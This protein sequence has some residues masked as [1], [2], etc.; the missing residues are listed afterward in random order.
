[1][2]EAPLA[3]AGGIEFSGMAVVAGLLYGGSPIGGA[4]GLAELAKQFSGMLGPNNQL[5]RGLDLSQLG[6]IGARPQA[7]RPRRRDGAIASG[8]KRSSVDDPLN[9]MREFVTAHE[10]AHQ[11]WHGLIG[12]DSQENPFLDESL[13]QYTTLVYLEDR[14]GKARAERDASMN[15]KLGYLMMRALGTPD[16]PVSRPAAEFPSSFAYAGLVY[17]KAPYFFHALRQSLGDRAFFD[18]LRAYA[19]R[20]RFRTARPQDL[21]DALAMGGRRKEIDELARRWLERA[22]GDED[23]GGGGLL[24]LFGGAF[25]ES[26]RASGPSRRP[27]VSP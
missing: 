12:S 14:Y 5:L 11:W 4:A 1:V 24:A 26:G 27:G 15:V 19:E 7:L 20:H 22:H 23:M 25:G 17:G 2:A 3:G 10:V 21:L 18:R 13:A 8:R 6:R 9:S 16:G